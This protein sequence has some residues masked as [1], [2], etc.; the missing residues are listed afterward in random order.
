[1]QVTKQVIATGYFPRP[2][3]EYIHARLRRFN[4]LVNHRR[5]GKT[6]LAINEII[7]KSLRNGRKNPYYAY[8]APTY[9][10]AKRIAWQY[11]KDYTMN[12]P[13]VTSNE[14]ELKI[15]VPRNGD[16]ITIQLLGAE[17]PDSLRGLYLDGVVLDEFAEMSPEIWTAVIR[18]AL[19][20]RMGWAI[21]IGT[22]KGANHFHELYRK[23]RQDDSGEWFVGLFKASETKIIPEKELQAAKQFMSNEFYLQEFEC[24]FTAALVGAYYKEEMAFLQREKR[25]IR[26][27]HDPHAQVYTG[28][29]LGIDDSTAIW[30]IQVVGQEIHAIDHLEVAGKGLSWIVGEVQKKGYNYAKHFL[31]HDTK[32]RE[33][34]T[35][36]TREETIRKL[37]L[38]G[39]EIV[40]RQ[41]VEDGIEA[42]RGL[43][44]RMWMDIDNCAYGIEALKSYQREFDAKDNV[45]RA[46]PKHDWSS[47]SAD[48]MR[49]FA[50]GF[51]GGPR[52]NSRQGFEDRAESDYDIMGW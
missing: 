7:D 18:P 48:A 37:G 14:A 31:P 45:F 13:G 19:S 46:K 49:T 6:V 43:L 40:S 8:V 36:V 11:L 50:L 26:V 3:Q 35:G 15:V 10:A 51:R 32:A 24:D 30:F 16:R 20:D 29:D 2:H 38:T 52:N 25:L 34:G 12:F 21:F 44:P 22:P 4:V 23:A 5:F 41:K 42:V 9:G 1:M 17:N 27:P 39:V 33:L 28:W 47:H